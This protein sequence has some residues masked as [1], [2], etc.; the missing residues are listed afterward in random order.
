M[1]GELLLLV[2]FGLYFGM[3]TLQ[4]IFEKGIHDEPHFWD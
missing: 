4:S 2:P 3:L 1:G